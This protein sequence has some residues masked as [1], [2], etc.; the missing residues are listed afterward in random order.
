MILGLLGIAAAFFIDLAVLDVPLLAEGT[1]ILS[2][3]YVLRTSLIAVGSGLFVIA[4]A[5]P[6]SQ[7]GN[8]MSDWRLEWES[9]GTLHWF[10]DESGESSHFSVSLKRVTIWILMLLSLGF[11][12]IFL[13]YPGFFS[14]LGREDR[15]IE[16][17]SAAILLVNSGL[18][19]YAATLIYKKWTYQKRLGVLI[20]LGFAL[21]FFVIGMEEISWFQRYIGFET[22]DSFSG[23]I[24][25]ETNLHNFATSESENIYYFSSFIFLIL[26][27]F[28]VHHSASLEYDRLLIFVPSPFVAYAGTLFISY[29]YDMWNILFSQISYFITLFIIVYSSFNRMKNKGGASVEVAL[30]ATLI[31]IQVTFL[32][33]GNYFVRLHDVTEYKELLLPLA[34]MIYAFD[35]LSRL[36]RR[37]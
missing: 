25:G 7:S 19:V 23:N 16:M 34:F 14:R 2:G 37:M 28:L 5:Q 6:F 24:Q 3:L 4:V 31:F 15:P 13:N 33:F 27:P 12:F 35:V 11:V 17:L 18:F 1:P 36:S 20:A 29:N 30:L 8:A 32:A 9:W 26:I 22:P 10:L 21:G